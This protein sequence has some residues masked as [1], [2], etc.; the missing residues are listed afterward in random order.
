MAMILH[1]TVEQVFERIL[2]YG[3][4]AVEVI[5]AVI[6]FIYTFRALYKLLRGDHPGCHS[7]LTEG[8]STGLSFLLGSEVLNTIIAPDWSAVGM[9]CAILMMRAG[10]TLLVHWENKMEA[11]SAAEAAERELSAPKKR[12]K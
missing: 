5:G 11:S 2:K 12:E 4:T 9:T 3:I 1:E 7:L 10:M 6:V 8:I